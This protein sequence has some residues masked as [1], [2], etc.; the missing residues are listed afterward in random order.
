MLGPDL[1]VAPVLEAGARTRT[2]YLP[3]GVTWVD[4]VDGRAFEGGA[5]GRG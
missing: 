1:L 2:L 4:P 3:A 5:V